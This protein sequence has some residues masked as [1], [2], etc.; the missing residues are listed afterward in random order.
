MYIYVYIYDLSDV[1]TQ[2]ET[3]LMLGAN[4]GANL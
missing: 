1:Y 4:L 2:H 3:D